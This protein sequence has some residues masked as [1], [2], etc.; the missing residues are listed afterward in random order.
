MD[1]ALALLARDGVATA[2]IAGG[3]QRVPQLGQDEVDEVVDLQSLGL[4]AIEVGKIDVTL[5]AMATLQ[6]MADHARLPAALREA[7]YREGPNTLRHAATLGGALVSAEPTSELLAALLVYEAR[8]DVQDQAGVR[9][10]ALADFLADIPAALGNG[11]VTG[12]TLG[13]SGRCATARVARTPA[14]API[15]AAVAR[16]TPDRRTLLAL[17]GVAALPVLVN[18][19]DVTASI[20]PPGDFRGSSQYRRAMAVTLAGRVLEEIA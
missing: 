9:Q 8:V 19:D 7:A 17:C 15:V 13:Q 3:T 2:V 6:A 11:L 14:D 20:D 10:L 12:I 5:G 16:R 4:A 18:P 1:E